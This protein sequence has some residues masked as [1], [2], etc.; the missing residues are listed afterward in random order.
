MSW[1]KNGA[2]IYIRT[3]SSSYSYDVGCHNGGSLQI[4]SKPPSNAIPRGTRALHDV[5]MTRTSRVTTK[6]PAFRDTF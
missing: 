5:A 2:T 6:K 1:V 4:V 3:S